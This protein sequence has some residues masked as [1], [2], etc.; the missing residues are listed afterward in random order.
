M[1]GSRAHRASKFFPEAPVITRPRAK[2]VAKKNY[3]EVILRD[4]Q[5][6]I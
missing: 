4:D 5:K 2:T 1:S 6:E 3:T